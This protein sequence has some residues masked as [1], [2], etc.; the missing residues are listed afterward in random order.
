MKYEAH[1][2]TVNNN[3]KLLGREVSN[4][5]KYR[6]MYGINSKANTAGNE[7]VASNLLSPD[8]KRAGT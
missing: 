2:V 3:I 4:I 7:I 5:H 8:S 1:N 6:I